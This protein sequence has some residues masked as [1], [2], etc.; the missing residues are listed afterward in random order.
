VIDS[1]LKHMAI[2]RIGNDT[3]RIPASAYVAP[4]ATVIG[5]VTLGE[6]ASV[7]PGAVVRGDDDAIRI[8]DNTNVQDGA[9]LHVDPG[10]PMSVGAN[11]TIGHQAMLHGC[12]IGDGALI[13][14]QAIVYN[15]A[16]IGKECL[17][18]AGAIVTEGKVFA[19]RTLIVGAPAKA[20][21]QLSDADVAAM[22]TNIDA[23][24]KR[25]ALFKTAL[26]RLD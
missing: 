12:T 21:R 25:G 22:R 15:K 19:D 10:L 26:E 14:I 16:V 5:K 24:V 7:W 2:Y 8:G 17:V 1:R 6:H 20:I 11:V 23:Y 3:P 13:G 9:V 4:G 18:A